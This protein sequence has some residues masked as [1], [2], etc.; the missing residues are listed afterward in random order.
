MRPFIATPG[1]KGSV[2]ASSFGKA[3][4]SSARGEKMD[5]KQVR[6]LW[7]KVFRHWP[8][9]IAPWL[10]LPR[11]PLDRKTWPRACCT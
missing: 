3:K 5:F 8:F 11:L 7:V 9:I 6:R 4:R 10:I 1:L 2:I